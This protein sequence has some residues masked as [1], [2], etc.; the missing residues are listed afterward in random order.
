VTEVLNRTITTKLGLILVLIGGSTVGLDLGPISLTGSLEEVLEYRTVEPDEVG[1]PR[2]EH[3]FSFTPHLEV[4]GVPLDLQFLVSS[5][6]SSIRQASNRYRLGA[7]FGWVHLHGGDRS[8]HFSVLSLSGV[9]VRG[10]G[11][12]FRLGQL[13]A[14]AAYGLTRRAIMGTDTCSASFNRWLYAGK[15]GYG[16]LEGSHV[17]LNFVSTWDDYDSVYAYSGDTIEVLSPRENKVASVDFGLVLFGGAFGLR[18]EVA[19]SGYA[20]DSRSSRIE[21]EGM[22]NSLDPKLTSEFDLAYRSE[23]DLSLGGTALSATF[24][25]FGAGYHALGVDYLGRDAREWTFSLSQRLIRDQLWVSAHHSWLW[26]NLSGMN[27]ATSTTHSTSIYASLSVPGLPYLTLGFNPYIH[28]DDEEND[29]LMVDNRLLGYSVSMGHNFD[30][31]RMSHTVDLD[32]SLQDFSDRNPIYGGSTDYR[33]TALSAACVHRFGFPLSLNWGASWR[34]DERVDGDS[35]ELTYRAGVSYE[36]PI[37]DLSVQADVTYTSS[38]EDV[39]RLDYG[40][41]VRYIVAALFEA[42]LRAE[43]FEVTADEGTDGSYPGFL[44]RLT[45]SKYF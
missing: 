33:S 1:D 16:D 24:I 44:L 43:R 15:L 3:F 7:D 21:V 45:L 26:N 17:H 2:F 38:S 30:F 42:R 35:D 11:V 12:G 13:R 10:G 40:A 39:S 6:E 14:E 36:P 4:S 32:A 22:L 37:R 29:S 20:R 34:S 9:N 18:G 25:H 23:M 41:S 5:W 8:P 19:G 28:S 31:L 27:S